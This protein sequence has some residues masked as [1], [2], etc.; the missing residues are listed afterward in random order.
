MIKRSPRR[1]LIISI[2][3][4]SV[5]IFILVVIYFFES[6]SC[7]LL[8]LYLS[9]SSASKRLK[10]FERQYLSVGL[11]E[12][13]SRIILSSLL[14]CRLNSFR[15]F[16]HNSFCFGVIGII[17]E[18]HIICKAHTYSKYGATIKK[19]LRNYLW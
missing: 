8:F 1:G 6:F 15:L 18:P 7:S 4:N 9:N 14:N 19:V 2:K 16:I 3:A 12:R 10:V 11:F 17:Y 13:V 5:C